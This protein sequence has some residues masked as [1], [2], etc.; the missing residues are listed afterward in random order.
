MPQN[1]TRPRFPEPTAQALGLLTFSQPRKSR[2]KRP[3]RNVTFGQTTETELKLDLPGNRR[4]RLRGGFSKPSNL[5]RFLHC[6]PPNLGAKGVYLPSFW[7]TAPHPQRDGCVD[8]LL[9]LKK[10][11]LSA[12]SHRRWPLVI[13]WMQRAESL[14]V[15]G[16]RV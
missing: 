2:L 1:P 12:L 5:I 11:C 13:K 9:R 8:L 3:F 15:P 7:C 10:T 14:Q 4:V 16:E 6:R